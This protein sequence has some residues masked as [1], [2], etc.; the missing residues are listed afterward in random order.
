MSESI[1]EKFG[2]KKYLGQET[3]ARTGDPVTARDIRHFALAIDDQNPMYYDEDVAKKGKYSSLVAPLGY[4]CSSD[5]NARMERRVKDM[6]EDAIVPGT[7]LAIPEIPNV[8]ALGWV[9]GNEEYEFYK[10]IYVGDRVSVKCKL[11]DMYEKEGRSGTLVFVTSELTY[12]NQK[13]ELLAIH[14]LTMI[15]MPRK[16]IK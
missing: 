8:W 10:R 6:G 15:G 13:G 1:I 2:W 11:V 5:R 7:F 16:E 3:G 9:R 12:S 14:R 4:I